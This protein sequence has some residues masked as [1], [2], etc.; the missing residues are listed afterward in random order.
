[1]VALAKFERRRVRS[2]SERDLKDRDALE[3]LLSLSLLSR[4]GLEKETVIALGDAGIA[5]KLNGASLLRAVN[6][7]PYWQKASESAPAHLTRLEPDKA[8][9]AFLYI[10]L[11]DGGAEPH[12]KSWMKIVAESKDGQF[13]QSY[14]RVNFDLSQ[15]DRRASLELE[16]CSAE[17]FNDT[18]VVAKN[19][20]S[21]FR[22]T[23]FLSANLSRKVA[24]KVQFNS[25]EEDVSYLS[26]FY[27]SNQNFAAGDTEEAA[28]LA[29]ECIN[30]IRSHP[31]RDGPELQKKLAIVL[32][33]LGGM[34][35]ENPQTYKDAVE[36]S[37]ESLEIYAKLLQNGESIV[38]PDLAR[39]YSN[40]AICEAKIGN[41]EKAY[42]LNVSALA[43]K[44]LVA[45]S[46]A[47]DTI[48]ELLSSLGNCCKFATSARQR[49]NSLRNFDD[50]HSIC[51][52][53]L[54]VD[55]IRFLPQAAITMMQFGEMFRKRHMD[56]LALEKFEEAIEMRRELIN[57]GPSLFID[58]FL[59]SV[60]EAVGIQLSLGQID[61]ALKKLDL[62]ASE[63]KRVETRHLTEPLV[64]L[65]T[66]CSEIV[67]RLLLDQRIP[68]AKVA[69]E[70]QADLLQGLA[71]SPSTFGGQ[72]IPTLFLN[73]SS[74]SNALSKQRRDLE[75]LGKIEEAERILKLDKM[76][77]DI[78]S[79]ERLP[80]ILRNK[81]DRLSVLGRRQEAL[82]ALDEAVHFLKY[83]SSRDFNKY[84]SEYERTNA[85]K[86]KALADWKDQL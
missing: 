79:L 6:L 76:K 62:A 15:I 17:A 48:S 55:R 77:A 33:N 84:H 70:I 61:E 12:L 60:R 71:T 13:I 1:M 69:A 30:A 34:L 38:R 67:S 83:L 45:K 49:R 11:L 22:P 40:L 81:F 39:A 82:A 16:S 7:T 50:A 3:K 44:R 80:V 63:F 64:G 57:A 35:S 66:S 27:A 36:Y 59:R 9:A 24:E 18:N 47:T 41:I 73:A 75:A 32:S 85:M 51:M 78:A 10:G 42:D 53:L 26:L 37:R 54:Q 5:Q 29:L 21:I 25:E 52:H 28:K 58:P 65:V 72:Q 68:E 43:E 31:R 2:Y 4:V 20:G 14:G 8:A 23:D 56:E 19:I 74:V 46:G 86:R